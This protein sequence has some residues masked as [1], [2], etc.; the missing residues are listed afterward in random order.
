MKRMEQPTE[1]RDYRNYIKR[2][3]NKVI[4]NELVEKTE[5]FTSPERNI[6]LTS[7]EMKSQYGLILD[8]H[9]GNLIGYVDLGDVEVNYATLENT[10][11]ISSHV[12]PVF[13][14]RCHKSL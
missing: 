7:D 10:E 14:S 1:T 2:G 8:K 3:I 12:L 11:E 4:I 13:N 5:N 6:V 9:S